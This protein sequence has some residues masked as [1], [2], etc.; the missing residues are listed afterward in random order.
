MGQPA[1]RK[2]ESK[3]FN[4][5]GGRLARGNGARRLLIKLKL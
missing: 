2:M 5:R 1:S 3:A 4:S